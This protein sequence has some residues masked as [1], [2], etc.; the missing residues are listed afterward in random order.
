MLCLTWPFFHLAVTLNHLCRCTW[1]SSPP[2]RRL[3]VRQSTG[4]PT[5]GFPAGRATTWLRTR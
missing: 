3:T 4:S 5:T 2:T 1:T